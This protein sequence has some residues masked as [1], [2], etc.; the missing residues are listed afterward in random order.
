MQAELVLDCRAALGEGPVWDERLEC[1]W[2]VDIEQKKMHRYDPNHQ[3]HEEHALPERVGSFA[4][5]EQGG[6]IMAGERGWSFFDPERTGEERWIPI[7]DP[8][9]D[10]P[11]N[12]FNDGKCDS[13]GRFLAGTMSSGN[14]PEAAFY[15]LHPN[16]Q[17]EKLFGE[18]TCSNGIA[19]TA[20]G[21]V[22]YYIDTFTRRVDRFDYDAETGR[23]SNR[24]TAVTYREGGG[25]PD[26]M[27]I[28]EEGMIWV[29]EWGGWNVSRWNPLTGERLMIVDVPAANVTSCVFGGKDMDELYITTAGGNRSSA[30]QPHAGGLFRA[31]VGIKGRTMHRFAG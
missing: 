20:E 13:S 21:D 6:F 12:R 2:F 16:L 23:P 28:D 24:R 3:A 15:V 9:P 1:V 19:W 11:R 14:Q 25:V 22:M 17:W 27:T 5:R 8:E 4:I 26:G 30:D 31:N 18:V 10:L 7:A 29:A